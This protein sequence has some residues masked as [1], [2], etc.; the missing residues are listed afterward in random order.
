MTRPRD[1]YFWVAAIVL[2]Q[3]FSWAFSPWVP[4]DFTAPWAILSGPN[5]FIFFSRFTS[6]HGWVEPG[7]LPWAVPGFV[8][9]VGAAFLALGTSVRPRTRVALGFAAVLAWAGSGIFALM[10]LT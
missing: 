2:A 3:A 4:K 1:R 10:M 5:A 8:V 6:S 7:W 9:S